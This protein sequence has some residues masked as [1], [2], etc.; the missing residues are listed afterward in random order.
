MKVVSLGVEKKKDS[1]SHHESRSNNSQPKAGCLDEREDAHGDITFLK[2]RDK[3]EGRNLNNGQIF[4][5]C[6]EN[7]PKM[8]INLHIQKTQ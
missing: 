1:W 7:F 6:L 2:G 8:C 5:K 4:T 3:G